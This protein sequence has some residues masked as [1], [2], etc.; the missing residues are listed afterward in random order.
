MEKLK[1]INLIKTIVKYTLLA[2][3]FAFLGCIFPYMQAILPVHENDTC[4][5]I[6]F[7]QL[8][9]TENMVLRYPI[10]S[11]ADRE[12]A[13]FYAINILSSFSFYLV[14]WLFLFLNIQ[15]VFRIRHMKDRLGIKREMTLIVGLWS[16]FDAF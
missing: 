15:A 3:L 11:I 13:N 6:Y 4:L 10:L 2:A 1:E 8:G 12:S 7:Y 16:F 14:N 9:D 5:C